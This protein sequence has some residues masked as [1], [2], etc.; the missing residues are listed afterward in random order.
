[1]GMNL[2]IQQLK[3]KINRASDKLR[4]YQ[5]MVKQEESRFEFHTRAAK[6]TGNPLSGWHEALATNAGRRLDYWTRILGNIE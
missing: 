6:H 2:S 1:M 3:D 5:D 4:P